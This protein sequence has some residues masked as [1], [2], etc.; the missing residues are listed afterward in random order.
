MS[1]RGIGRRLFLNTAVSATAWLALSEPSVRAGASRPAS[2]EPPA[3]WSWARRPPMGW[4][5][6]DSFGTTVTE[7][8]IRAQTDYM[9]AHLKAHGWEYIVVDI[10]WYEPNA[11]GHN[12]RPDA[13]LTLD[14]FG[15]LWPALNRFPSAAGGAGFTPLA[16]FIHSKGLKFGLHL[17]RGIP[18][19][20]VDRDLPVKS[21]SYRA[22]DIADRSSTVRGTRTC[23]AST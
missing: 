19:Q 21:T 15:R 7:A 14:D 13:V 5:S 16:E 22:R 3:F 10:Q 17:M 1:N 11:R 8:Q 23:S 20:A 9:S 4:N 18:R 6:W 2:V 12:Y